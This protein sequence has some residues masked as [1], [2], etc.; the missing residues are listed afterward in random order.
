MRTYSRSLDSIASI[1][2]VMVRR[3]L[4]ALA[5][6]AGMAWAADGVQQQVRAVE[7]ALAR[8]TQ[9]Q[10]SIYQQ[11]QMAQELRRS[12]ERQM[13]P[14]PLYGVPTSPNYEDIKR[15]EAARAQ[16]V[17]DLQAEVDRLYARYRELE[18][19]KKPLL[20]QLSAL[21]QQ[22]TD[23]PPPPAPQELPNDLPRPAY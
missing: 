10:Q 17:K 23:A 1:A 21:A 20:E 9:E 14:L 3:L 4:P 2:T 7:A 8:I 16:R 11:F 22:R 19:Q 5:L 6:L 15:D 13:Q 18:E 12:D